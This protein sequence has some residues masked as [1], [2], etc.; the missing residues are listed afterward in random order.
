MAKKIKSI[1]KKIIL[2]LIVVVGLSSA[3]T[4]VLVYWVIYKPNVS[5]G[6]KKSQFIYIKTGA[7]FDD[8]VNLLFDNKIIINKKSFV[9]LANKKKYTAAVKPGK[10]RLLARMG[11][12]EL[13][14]ILRAGIQEPVFINFAG[15][16]TPEQL[17]TRVCNRLE[18]DSLEMKQ[19]FNDSGYISKYGFTKDNFS[20]LFIPNTYEFYWNT[21]VDEFLERMAKEYRTFWTEERKAKARKLQL[22]QTEVAV[23]ASIVQGEQWRFNDEKPIIAGL[24]INRL[25]KGMLLQSDP[26]V[27]YA[28]GDFTINRVLNADKEI[29]SPYNTYKYKGLPPGP[30]GFPE[31]SSLDAVLNYQHNDY[32]FMCAKEDLS[33][34]HYFAKTYEQHQV[35]AT[36][37]REALNRLNI[38]R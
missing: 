24:Y 15:L 4:G 31:V 26:T 37:Y 16:R 7:T 6:T 22:S 2:G 13:I 20:A 36:K 30:I 23:L 9:W 8:V 3:I 17:I 10:Y 29:D 18:A 28:V 21:S 5:L 34:R 19:K 25:E 11:N 1:F 27:I 38:K 35:Y 33:G 12:N 32:L 14:N